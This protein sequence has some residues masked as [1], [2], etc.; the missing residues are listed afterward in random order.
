METITS[1]IYY[2]FI[3]NKSLE[4]FKIKY[5]DKL[6]SLFYVE[7]LPSNT[8]Y[9]TSIIFEIFKSS[10]YFNRDN[11]KTISYTNRENIEELLYTYINFYSN[12][13]SGMKEVNNDNN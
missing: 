1:A 7:K 8:D 9:D 5:N 12:E 4:L 10:N 6:A 13:Y 2:K 3:G 11:G